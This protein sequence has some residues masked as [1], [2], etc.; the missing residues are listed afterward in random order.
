MQKNQGAVCENVR[1]CRPDKISQAACWAIRG[2]ITDLPGDHKAGV[3]LNLSKV[4]KRFCLADLQIL[5]SCHRDIQKSGVDMAIAELHH[6]QNPRIEAGLAMEF[7][8]CHQTEEE[9]IA[10]IQ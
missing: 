3:V 9:A 2:S 1:V 8:N 6:R 10:S 4:K 7:G 5:K